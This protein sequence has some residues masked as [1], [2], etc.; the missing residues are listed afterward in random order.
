[1]QYKNVVSICLSRFLSEYKITDFY[2]KISSNVG[3]KDRTSG[4][5]FTFLITKYPAEFFVVQMANNNIDCVLP[6]IL[7]YL[8]LRAFS[9][10]IFCLYFRFITHFAAKQGKQMLLIFF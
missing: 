4:T 2:N 5:I 6:S 3:A 9:E 8:S 7:S 1:M 10:F